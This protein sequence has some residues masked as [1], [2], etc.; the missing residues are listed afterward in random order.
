[1]YKNVCKCCSCQNKTLFILNNKMP[2]VIVLDTS[3]SMHRP[4]QMPDV[5]EPFGFRNLAVHGLTYLLDYM[6]INCKLEFA[7]LITFNSNR[8]TVVPFTRDFESIKS[9]LLQL[10]YHETSQFAKALEAVQSLV[11]E[12]WGAGVPCQV[13]VVTDGAIGAEIGQ[14]KNDMERHFSVTEKGTED[15]T[16]PLPFPF[17]CKLHIACLS[18]LTD[19]YLKNSLPIYKKI[20]DISGGGGQLFTPEGAV[21]FKSIQNMFMKLAD[22]YYKPFHGVLHCGTLTSSVALSPPPEP[23]CKARDF[24]LV[25]A[26]MSTDIVICGFISIGDISS[27]PSHSRHLILPLQSFKEEIKPPVVKLE[28]SETNEED[29][30]NEDGKQPS[31]CVL[32]HGSLRVEGMVAICHLGGDWY[33]MLY[34]WAD[35]KKKSNLMLSAFEPGPHV[36]PWLGNFT[37]L[38]PTELAPE[39]DIPTFPI[40][41]SEKRSYAQNCVVWIRQPGLQADIQKILRHARKLPEKTQNFYKELNRLRRA[42][43]SFGFHELLEGMATILD[44]ECTLLPG[45]AHPDAALQLTHCANALRNNSRD[46]NAPV[47]PLRTKFSMDD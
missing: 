40:K 16:F 10:E 22:L 28:N 13:V 47:L 15:S 33:G 3:L 17:P 38:G 27:P 46:Y 9:A 44:R 6:N 2:T 18:N 5:P 37:H 1:M 31:F 19:P 45:S 24:E 36:I 32:L 30:A 4:V 26:E 39:S 34:S 7:A 8:E 23:F 12:E 11:M 20:I 43:L 14:L 35:S 21:N 25:K 42:A 41:P 29:S